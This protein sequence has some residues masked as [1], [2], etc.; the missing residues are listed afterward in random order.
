M[1]SLHKSGCSPGLVILEYRAF[2]LLPGQ[3]ALRIA[4]RLWEAPRERPCQC[5]LDSPTGTPLEPHLSPTWEQHHCLAREWAPSDHRCSQALDEHRH[6]LCETEIRDGTL[7]PQWSTQL[8]RLWPP[9]LQ[10]GP[11][12]CGGLSSSRGSFPLLH[13]QCTLHPW[14]SHV[15]CRSG[16]LGT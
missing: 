2:F 15:C 6:S 7:S 16:S 1:C 4:T 3:W 12:H 10:G 5:C 8:S 9:K 13:S 11:Q 14:T